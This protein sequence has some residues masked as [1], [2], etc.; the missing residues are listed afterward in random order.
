MVGDDVAGQRGESGADL[1]WGLPTT[2]IGEGRLSGS[3]G[4]DAD[5]ASTPT[6]A[7]TPAPGS[8]WARLRAR[9]QLSEVYDDLRDEGQGADGA[10]DDAGHSAEEWLDLSGAPDAVLKHS[11][12]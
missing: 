5:R 7:Q 12:S 11:G 10:D 3:C 2:L 8:S 4:L 1:R 6:S 9:E